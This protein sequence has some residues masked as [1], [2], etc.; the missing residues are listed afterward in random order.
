[1]SVPNEG[2]AALP[3]EGLVIPPCPHF[4]ACGG[5]QLQHLAYAAQLERKAGL[6]RCLLSSPDLPELQVHASPPLGYRNRIRLTLREADGEL[7]AGYLGDA[8]A[9]DQ[10]ASEL[11][12]VPITQ[13]PIAAPLLWRA[14]EKFLE[15]A[16]AASW[17][18][19]P[20]FTP[21]QLEL[22]TNADETQLQLA[23]Y[24]RTAHK[25]LPT[26]VGADF[27]KMCDSLRA[28]VPELVGAGVALLP[29]A[30]RGRRVEQPHYGPAWGSAGLNY[31]ISL[32]EPKLTYWVPRGA[33][34]QVNR[35]LLPELVRL[36]SRVAAGVSDPVLAWDLYAG[37]G[38]FSRSLARKYEQVTA[39]EIAEPAAT[40][41]AQ[42][43]IKNLRAIKAT[44]LD[45][46]RGAAIQR[47]RPSLIVVDPPRNG[48]GEGACSLLARV[49]ARSMIY[50][51]CSPQALATDLR[52]LRQTD[53]RIAELHL[54]DLFPQTEHIETVA[55]LDRQ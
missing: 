34:F 52:R 50:V 35:F 37:V 25:A 1:M 23:V 39:V 10:P 6:L 19:T 54:F 15:L 27:A 47:E 26:Q 18:Q 42:T 13:C 11:K 48:L 8:E 4:G 17:L 2:F 44:T 16:R 36:V 14:A 24:L 12:F 55:V 20:H 32:V 9:D 38:L 43:K 31:A 41:L 7:R 53:Y 21:D 29:Q 40:A 33:F 46:L 3:T 45:F 51:S 28:A 22:F 5:C 30:T 49:A